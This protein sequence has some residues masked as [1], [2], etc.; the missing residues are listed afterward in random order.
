MNRILKMVIPA[1]FMLLLFITGTIASAQENY[2]TYTYDS[3]G[4]AVPS[5][6]G[7]RP[8]RSVSGT[9]LGCGE[10]SEPSDIY[11][12][13]DG[14]FYIADK[15]NNRIVCVN[16]DFTRAAGEYTV[17]MDNGQETSLNAPE[18]VFVSDSGLMYIA[19]TG[20]SRI[21][22][23]DPEGNALQIITKPDSPVY[24]NETFNPVKVAADKAG[25]IYAVISGV[26]GGAAL[27]DRDGEFKGFFG[28]NRT[29][30]T[31]EVIIS[32]FRKLF[33][34]DKMR[35]GSSRTVPAGITNFDIDDEG[36]LFTVTKSE[37]AG[38]D[39]VKKVSP[40]GT[41]LFAGME[42][43]FGDTSSDTVT[44]FVDTDT[45]E[46]G[47]ICCLDAENG[48]IFQYDEKG[49][50]LFIIGERSDRLGGFS[51]APSAV[52]SSGTNI[53]VT[54]S[55]KNNV[56]VFEETDFGNVVHRASEL[57]NEGR[58]EESIEP[59]QQVL[60][61]DGNYTA[62][63]KGISAGL[64]SLGNYAGA[65][66]Y[67]ELSGSSYLYDKAFEG[68]RSEWLHDNFTW[69]IAAL[70]L[71]VL[72]CCIYG[73]IRKS[74]HS[75]AEKDISEMYA[76][77]AGQWIAHTV[78]HP[79][80]G[81]EDLRWK[82]A[83]SLSAANVIIFFWF[84]GEILHERFSGKQF[85]MVS[86][87][88]FSIVPFIVRTVVLFLAWTVGNRSVSTLLDGEGSLR[89]IYIYSSYALVPYAAGLYIQTLLSHVLIREE[90]I[91]IVIPGAVGVIWSALLMLTAVKAVQQFS[92]GRTFLS[93]F[94]SV[95]AM[96]VMLILLVTVAALFQ[97]I[98]VFAA[99]VY[100]EIM[101]RIRE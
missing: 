4:E 71:V 45:D 23:S 85:D 38:A 20:N 52:E 10:F 9:E 53:Y 72:I 22:V 39:R 101:Y 78:F 35:A 76:F 51:A 33:A 2:S 97:Q 32:Y 44:R 49:S 21:I 100:S 74:K 64:F 93:V 37:D 56:T 43:E 60:R 19:D 66:E 84:S 13:G 61:Q 30:R 55:I 63:Y 86:N 12:G 95:S 5:Q 82:R 99:S 54:D 41:N 96:L 81:F 65:M 29:A 83:G 15:G 68:R 67:A 8:V 89:K 34:T 62:A 87:E 11:K 14:R 31:A 90:E 40:G 36:F 70:V 88:Q 98:Y 28:A 50:L 69:V 1:V 46:A 16:E 26:T 94:M 48:R 47:R 73:H 17:F 58:Y 59:W 57:Y 42:T 77:T 91:F 6:A 18:G 27:F 25:N 80:E 3:T 79:F 24:D 75:S 92:L 7:Y